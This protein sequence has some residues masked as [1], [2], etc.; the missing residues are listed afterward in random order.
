MASEDDDELTIDEL[1]RRIG[2]TVRNIRAH[3]S[4]GLLPAPEVRGRTGYYGPDHVARLE[5]IQELQ[6]DG[7]NLDLIRRLLDGAGGSSKEVL[8]FK[9]ALARPFVSDEE[10]RPVNLLELAEEWGTAD[11]SLLDRAIR[12]GLVR[13]RDDGGF[14]VTSPRLVSHGREL[15]KLGVPLGRSLDVI[16]SVREQADRI[17]EV[18]VAL[19]LDAVWSPFEQAGQ[20]RER[21]PDVQ[22]ALERL[23]PLAAESVVAIFGMAM[24][25]AVERE[26]GRTV[27]RIAN[28]REAAER[29]AAAAASAPSATPARP[30]TSAPPATP[31][32]PVTSAPSG[33]PARP[34][35]SAPPGTPAPS[36]TPARTVTSARPATS[37]T[38]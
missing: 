36:A 27:E 16:G 32:R 37:K 33:T 13:Q 11:L 26:F 22:E 19:F 20:P 2:M 4:R 10:P 12:V 8:R 34:V 28:E 9:H 38:T 18:F 35:T 17:A 5:L 21:W 6:A 23:H 1:A 7:F 15:A 24:S 25:S 14:E 29:S 30:V 3:Q 31:A